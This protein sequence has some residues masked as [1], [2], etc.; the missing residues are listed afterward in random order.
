MYCLVCLEASHFELSVCQVE[1]I[2]LDHPWVQIPV[3]FSVPSAV[4]GEE[5]GCAVV[6]SGD[7]PL[8]M[9]DNEIIKSM[10]KLMKDKKFAPVK[11][12]LQQ[13]TECVHVGTRTQD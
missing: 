4:Y 9:K 5:V 11:V 3:C 8:G 12:S 10:R 1:E 7:A 2:L 6:L 13:L